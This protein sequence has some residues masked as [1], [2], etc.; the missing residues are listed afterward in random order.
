M[1]KPTHAARRWKTKE[2]QALR[3]A[4][5]PLGADWE[6]VAKAMWNRRSENALSRRFSSLE[7][8]EEK[9]EAKKKPGSFLSSPD[10]TSS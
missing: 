2:D 3:E 7:A 8:A 5:K 6:A 1:G 4:V 10:F 9:D